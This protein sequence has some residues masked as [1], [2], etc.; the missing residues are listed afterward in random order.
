MSKLSLVKPSPGALLKTLYHSQ[1]VIIKDT[2]AKI[3]LFRMAHII[4]PTL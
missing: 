2:K 3:S 1:H 4:S